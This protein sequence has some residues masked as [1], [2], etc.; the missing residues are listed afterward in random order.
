MVN[1]INQILRYLVNTYPYPD[2]LSRTRTTKLLYLID[3]GSVQKTGNQM[4]EIEWYLDNYGPYTSD[5]YN[6]ITNDPELSSVETVSPLGTK[7]YITK[8]TVQNEPLPYE[9]SND[10]RHIIDNI[11]A[12]TKDLSFNTFI[13]HVYETDPIVQSK[14]HGRLELIK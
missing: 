2:D 4:T 1:K 10:E 8:S 6:V 3:W 5:V 11:I 12:E 9:L 13:N 7:K 14:S